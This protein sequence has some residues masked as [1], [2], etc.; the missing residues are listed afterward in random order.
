MRGK[1]GVSFNTRINERH[2]R[3]FADEAVCAASSILHPSIRQPEPISFS[4]T[5]WLDN[6]P[7]LLADIGKPALSQV[8]R[9]SEFMHEA[10]YFIFRHLLSLS[11][12]AQSSSRRVWG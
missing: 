9:E 4:P 1:E 5:Q 6:F 3:I 12:S 2:C 10:H 8:H 11:T 7:L